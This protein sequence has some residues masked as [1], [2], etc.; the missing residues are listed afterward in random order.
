MKKKTNK[1]TK[2]VKDVEKIEPLYIGDWNENSSTA[3]G[4]SLVVTQKVKHRITT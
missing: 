2:I 3:V 1:I 4:S